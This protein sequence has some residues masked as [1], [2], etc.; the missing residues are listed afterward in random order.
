[1]RGRAGEYQIIADGLSL[2]AGG[3]AAL[4]P[5]LRRRRPDPRQQ[6]ITL[7][8]ATGPERWAHPADQGQHAGPAGA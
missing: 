6:S 1:M 5:D 7:R 8:G 2:Q 4:Y 3:G